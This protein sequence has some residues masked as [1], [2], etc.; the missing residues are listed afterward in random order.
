MIRLFLRLPVALLVLA[1]LSWGMGMYFAQDPD[2]VLDEG[3]ER[4]TRTYPQARERE[5]IL[6][7]ARMLSSR[8][9]TGLNHL[10]LRSSALGQAK[11]FVTATHAASLGR[12]LPLGLL[13]AVAGVVA[14][15]LFRERMRDAR[16]YAS[17]TAAGLGR[18]LL[19]GGVLWVGLFGISPVG[20]PMSSCY[21]AFLAIAGGA[22]LYTANLPLRL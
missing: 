6:D 2:V 18:L 15:L 20:A 4:L 10:G 5:L 7:E 11:V 19:G 9:W 1:S 21:V 3:L 16:G 22:A 12:T 8:A 13:L 17:P 14:G